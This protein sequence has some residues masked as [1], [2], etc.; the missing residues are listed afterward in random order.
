MKS[1]SNFLI[2]RNPRSISFK[3]PLVNRT[4]NY[5]KFSMAKR[6]LLCAMTKFAPSNL[7]LLRWSRIFGQATFRGIERNLCQTYAT[8]ISLTS[9]DADACETTILDFDF[10][11]RIVLVHYKQ[12]RINNSYFV[13][14]VVPS[15]STRNNIYD[16]YVRKLGQP[17]LALN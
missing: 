9:P 4:V 11:R 16:L 1:F 10:V 2:T 7:S 15:Y 14:N 5:T 8:N 12:I 6:K 17:Y 3:E 13:L